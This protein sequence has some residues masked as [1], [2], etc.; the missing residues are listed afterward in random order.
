M[1]NSLDIID[2]LRLGKIIY[3]KDNINN[4]LEYMIVCLYS[5]S[6]KNKRYIYTIEYINNC[7]KMLKSNTNFDMCIDNM[8][9]KIWEEI[10]E[11]S[12]RS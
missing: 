6:K 2:F 11:S 10:N 8:L 1:V 4:Y 7:I 5:Y 9:M 12:N 3:D